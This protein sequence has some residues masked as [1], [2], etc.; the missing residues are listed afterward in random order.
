MINGQGG[1]TELHIGAFLAKGGRAVTLLYSTVLGGV[2]TIVPQLDQGSLVTIP[3]HFADIVITEYGI[4]RLLD[5]THQ[6]RAEELIKVAHPDHRDRL[7]DQA[8]E[9]FWPK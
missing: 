7:K 8:R 3:R 9:L 5:K 4:A 2:S 1:Q 6:E